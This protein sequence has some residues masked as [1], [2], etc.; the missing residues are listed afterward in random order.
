MS[1]EYFMKLAA[2]LHPAFTTYPREAPPGFIEYVCQYD[3][4]RRTLP[5]RAKAPLIKVL[6]TEAANNQPDYGDETDTRLFFPTRWVP[7]DDSDVQDDLA[8]NEETETDRA[9]RNELIACIKQSSGFSVDTG[10]LQFESVK[11]LHPFRDP[12]RTTEEGFE[13]KWERAVRL[14]K[15]APLG[16]CTTRCTIAI[17]RHQWKDSYGPNRTRAI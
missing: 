3:S 5:D 4:W 10:R 12:L 13:W 14:Y 11:D 16:K 6:R 1:S 7:A 2:S 8:A 9:Q 15:E 17:A